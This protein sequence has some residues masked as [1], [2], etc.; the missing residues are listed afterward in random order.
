VSAHDSSICHIHCC[1][2]SSYGDDGAGADSGPDLGSSLLK[3]RRRRNMSTFETTGRP[4]RL[5]T[6]AT[7]WPTSLNVSA[8]PSSSTQARYRSCATGSQV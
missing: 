1:H 2:S 5:S 8:R 4:K 6:G 7:M 3:N